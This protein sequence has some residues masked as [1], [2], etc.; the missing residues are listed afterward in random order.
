[1]IQSTHMMYARCSMKQIRSVLQSESKNSV[2]IAAVKIQQFYKRYTQR[3]DRHDV[4]VKIDHS[5]KGKKKL[6]LPSKTKKVKAEPKPITFD[7]WTPADCL[8]LLEIAQLEDSSERLAEF[9]TALQAGMAMTK[10]SEMCRYSCI[11]IMNI[12]FTYFD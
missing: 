9:I 4:P 3:R 2:E 6:T 7:A 11:H 10:V 12:S 5:S 1:M 8:S